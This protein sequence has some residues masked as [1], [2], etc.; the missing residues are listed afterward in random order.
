MTLSA[1]VV[2]AGTISDRHLAGLD[3]CP[4]TKLD[5][6]CDLDAD[7]ARRAARKYGI[8]AYSDM[9]DMLTAESLDWIHLCTGVQSH[10]P[11][12]RAAI[13]AGVPVMIEK[14]IT[15]STAD[16]EELQ[17]LAADHGV[18]VSEVQQHLFD[19]AVRELKRRIDDGELGRIRGVDTI[20][21]GLTKPD[22]PNRGSW[23]FDLAGGEF[24]EGLPHPLY[25]TLHLGGFPRG[26]EDIA[27]TTSLVDQYDRPF[28][29]DG[30]QVQFVAEGERLCSV[31]LIAGC[32]PQK[33]VHVHGEEGSVT[34]DLISQTLVDVGLNYDGSTIAKTRNNLYRARDRVLGT[35]ENGQEVVRGR[36]AND[37]EHDKAFTTHFYQIDLEAQ[38][39]AAGEP[40]PLPLEQSWWTVGLMEAIRGNPLADEPE[41][42]TAP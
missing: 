11:L 20:Y 9:D 21:A 27:A 35:F 19:P 15:E 23:A 14:P 26:R 25:V 32:A 42:Q 40:L 4:H 22:E 38:A 1:A 36:L 28:A 3:R 37:W 17:R 2:G 16:L 24:E 5:A 30:A 34:A 31:K 12:A 7:R 29:Y 18:G 41:I 33:L 10:L 39:L 6:V 13:E 8:L